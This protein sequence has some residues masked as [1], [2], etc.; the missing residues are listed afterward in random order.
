MSP[1]CVLETPDE[2]S[3]DYSR[4]PV[5][6]YIKYLATA[7]R[8]PSVWQATTGIFAESEAPKARDVSIGACS[9]DGDEAT[10]EVGARVLGSKMCGRV[11]MRHESLSWN[12]TREDCMGRSA[13]GR[14]IREAQARN[15]VQLRSVD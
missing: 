14:C 11:V 8:T 15:R 3:S 9:V 5:V 1:P 13:K 12:V 2:V 10:T 7:D 6:A 4:A